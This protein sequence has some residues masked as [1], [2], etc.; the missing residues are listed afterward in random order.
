MSE[1]NFTAKELKNEIW[2]PIPNYE[3]RYEASNLG[4]I[5]SIIIRHNFP[6]P[7]IIKSKSNGDGYLQLNL[8]NKFHKR[9]MF[10]VHRLVMFAFHGISDLQVNHKNGDKSNN[11]IDNLEYVT[12]TENNQHALKT[13][14]RKMPKGEKR[15][16]SKLSKSDVIYIRKMLDSKKMTGCALAEKFKVSFQL[17]SNIKRNLTWKHL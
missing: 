10:S 16:N 6:K 13:G 9:K 2:K 14:L 1:N 8:Y 12:Q 7:R 5:K 17:I 15:Y 4:R 3:G 11:R